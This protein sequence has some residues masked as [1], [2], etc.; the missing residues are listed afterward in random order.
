[1]ESLRRAPSRR[2]KALSAQSGSISARHR[3]GTWARPTHHPHRSGNSGLVHVSF[4]CSSCSKWGWAVR[5][6][7]SGLITRVPSL[8]SSVLRVSTQATQVSPLP[9]RSGPL[10]PPWRPLLPPRLSS[11]PGP[12]CQAGPRRLRP[13]SATGSRRRARPAPPAP[14]LG[15]YLSSSWSSSMAGATSGILRWCWRAGGAAPYLEASRRRRKEGLTGGARTEG[16]R[17]S[18][19][20]AAGPGHWAGRGDSASEPRPRAPPPARGGRRPGLSGSPALRSESARRASRET[21]AVGLLPRPEAETGQWAPEL[22]PWHLP[23]R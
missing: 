20:G 10:S 3:G 5:E 22:S 19:S 17:R 21:G 2:E 12:R 11:Q 23:S 16:R 15:R 6:L 1:M 13:R 18:R 9:S 7:N 8:I 4:I 14:L